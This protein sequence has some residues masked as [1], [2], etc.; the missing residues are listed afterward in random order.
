MR[1]PRTAGSGRAVKSLAVLVRVEFLPTERLPV[2]GENGVDAVLRATE[3][4]FRGLSPVFRFPLSLY[5]GFIEWA[6]F[7]FT[8]RTL[9]R[10]GGGFQRW[11]LSRIV[12][13]LPLW[14]LLGRLLESLVWMHYWDVADAGA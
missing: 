11:Y 7:F 1:Q 4:S 5:L 2:L 9:S 13:R 8:G 10:H 6:P 3:R 12:K 14:P